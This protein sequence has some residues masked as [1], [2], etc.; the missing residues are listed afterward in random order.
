MSFQC[1]FSMYGG[2]WGR[3]VAEDVAVRKMDDEHPPPDGHQFRGHG[4][5]RKTEPSATHD[6]FWGTC[7]KGHPRPIKPARSNRPRTKK[8][9]AFP[10]CGKTD[11]GTLFDCFRRGSLESR[12]RYADQTQPRPSQ[13]AALGTIGVEREWHNG[14]EVAS[15]FPVRT[16]DPTPKTLPLRLPSPQR[17]PAPVRPPAPRRSSPSA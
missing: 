16:A 17:L 14:N 1:S 3:M 13:Q 5:Q 8:R 2:G 12:V 10:Q 9:P 7:G 4:T 15:R 11:L 6:K